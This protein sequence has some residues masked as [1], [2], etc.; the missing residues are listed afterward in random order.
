MHELADVRGD[1]K[2]NFMRRAVYMGRFSQ[3]VRYPNPKYNGIHPHIAGITGSVN[4]Y[5]CA[6]LIELDLLFRSGYVVGDVDQ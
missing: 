1:A 2:G 4:D 6:L 3:T 5:V